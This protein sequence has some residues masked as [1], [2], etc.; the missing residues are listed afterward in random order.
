M[1]EAC[2]QIQGP[3]SPSGGPSGGWADQNVVR[4]HSPAPV[5]AFRRELELRVKVVILDEFFYIQMLQLRQ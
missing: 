3:W 1:V 4:G 5:K 2:K